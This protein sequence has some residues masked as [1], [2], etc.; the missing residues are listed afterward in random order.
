MEAI[1]QLHCFTDST[2]AHPHCGS[3][4][5]A[6]CVMGRYAQIVWLWTNHNGRCFGLADLDGMAAAIARLETQ[7]EL[8]SGG[9]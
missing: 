3:S 7:V 4:N 1:L 8:G 5:P 9:P 6:V 2:T